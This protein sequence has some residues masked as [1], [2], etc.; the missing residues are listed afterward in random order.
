MLVLDGLSIASFGSGEPVPGPSPL[1]LASLRGAVPSAGDEATPRPRESVRTSRTTP[2][3]T[4]PSP[5]PH[6]TPPPA[7]DAANAAKPPRLTPFEPETESLPFENFTTAA[8]TL[9]VSLRRADL[10][11]ERSQSLLSRAKSEL[12]RLTR[13]KA[14]LER[15]RGR[16]PDPAEL[17]HH[18]EALLAAPPDLGPPLSGGRDLLTL[19]IPDPRTG[20]PIEIRIQPKLTLPQNA[21]ALYERARNIERQKGAFDTRWTAVTSKLEAA[22]R[23]LDE[24]KALRSLDDLDAPA[25]ATGPDPRGRGGRQRY[26]TSRGL[27]ILFGRSAAENHDVTFKLAKREDIW[28]HVL[29]APGGHVI[30]RNPQGRASQADIAEA[31][32]LAAFLSERRTEGKVDVQY[33]ERKHV[34]PAG[35]GKGRVRVTHAEVMRVEPQDPA[36]RLRAR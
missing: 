6:I 4:A 30:L 21:N 29:D 32:S 5:S 24:A 7:T 8:A 13:L 22:G 36:G 10:F 17:R 23:A 20:E 15:D 2:P 25:K 11:R 18:A 14:A 19:S 33:T 12:S 1:D 9:Y 26:L 3:A 27:E 16:W 31:A 28:L 34:Q 35:G